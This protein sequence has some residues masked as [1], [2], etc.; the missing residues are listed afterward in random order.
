M[1]LG[2]FSPVMVRIKVKN[3]VPKVRKWLYSF[4]YRLGITL[5]NRYIPRIEKIRFIKSK[6]PPIFIM[7]GILIRN[8]IKVFLRPLFRLKNKN[9]RR[10][11]KDLIM[12]V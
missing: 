5:A 2:H 11:L 9:I 10:I 7:P 4:N 8:D 12:V 6:R 1:R 3:E